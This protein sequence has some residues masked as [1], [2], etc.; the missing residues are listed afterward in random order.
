MYQHRVFTQFEAASAAAAVLARYVDRMYTGTGH[1]HDP[2]DPDWREH[3]EAY[4]TDGVWTVFVVG[5]TQ[6]AAWSE[7]ELRIH[8]SGLW[9]PSLDDIPHTRRPWSWLIVGLEDERGGTSCEVQHPLTAAL[10][11]ATDED[12]LIWWLEPV[13][14]DT[15][16]VWGVLGSLSGTPRRSMRKYREQVVVSEPISAVLLEGGGDRPGLERWWDDA[17]DRIGTKYSL[18]DR[19]GYARAEAPEPPIDEDELLIEVGPGG[20]VPEDLLDRIS[21]ALID[22]GA[23]VDDW[24]GYASHLGLP[25]AGPELSEYLRVGAEM[26]RA[27]GYT[28]T[29]QPSAP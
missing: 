6:V 4:L 8:A 13:G 21:S 27:A 22:L 12:R 9:D 19:S 14:V 29:H 2:V 23:D 10:L 11:A 20:R 17:L 24:N 1:Q 15:L 28:V 3:V 25:V 26:A 16:S 5:A 7:G 18:G